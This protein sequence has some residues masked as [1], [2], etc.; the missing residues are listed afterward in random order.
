MNTCYC[1]KS[2][3]ELFKSADIAMGIDHSSLVE[4]HPIASISD[5]KNIEFFLPG[6]GSMYWDMS[7]IFL[8]IQAKIVKS[9][10]SA[11]S[12]SDKCG[13]INYLLNT[14]FSECHVSLNE[15]QISSE[16]NYAYKSIIQA[17]L[18]HS[19][20]S[21]K[22]IL[23]AALFEKDTVG[24]YDDVNIASGS[25]DGLKK[26]YS[27]TK[28]GKIFEM[29]GA[30]HIDLCNQPKLLINGVSIRIKLEKAKHTFTLMS[31]TGDFRLNIESASMF[32]RRCEITPSILIAHERALESSLA[33]IPFTRIEL[34][35]FT[36]ASGIKSIT[37][38]NAVS[39]PLPKRVCLCLIKKY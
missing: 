11:L 7:N 26:R 13:P 32:A 34:K 30:L 10:G 8:K 20:L 28:E 22:N 29:Y 27:R 3:L 1:S 2:E 5:S 12:A 35:N 25:N 9:D 36:L 15:R 38:P 23:S 17:L 16:N 37:I 33:Q 14:M 31:S 21:Q 24:H 4:F 19:E 18:F 6:Q 39:G